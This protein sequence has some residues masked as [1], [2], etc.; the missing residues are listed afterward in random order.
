MQCAY[1]VKALL[2][3]TIILIKD[4]SGHE[5]THHKMWKKF[6]GWTLILTNVCLLFQEKKPREGEGN[7]FA[8][9]TGSG[10][11]ILPTMS[12]KVCQRLYRRG[13]PTSRTIMALNAYHLQGEK[14][15]LLHVF[16]VAP[17]M[18]WLAHYWAGLIYL[19]AYITEQVHAGVSHS[20][21]IGKVHPEITI[22]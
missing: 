2:L 14:K 17:H 10:L 22:L 21:F 16:L 11:H 9:A 19:S 5:R 12:L 1:K 4:G 13:R 8:R 20:G 7:D 18:N 6:K 15:P 3:H